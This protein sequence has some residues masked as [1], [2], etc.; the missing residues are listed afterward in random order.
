MAHRLAVVFFTIISQLYRMIPNPQVVVNGNPPTYV[1]QE[2][3]YAK[4]IPTLVVPTGKPGTKSY[5]DALDELFHR[6]HNM[7]VV[8][9]RDRGSRLA[10][11]FAQNS[12][13]NYDIALRGKLLE[14]DHNDVLSPRGQRGLGKLQD[15]SFFSTN[16]SVLSGILA[17]SPLKFSVDILNPEISEEA[18]DR[19][20]EAGAEGFL[21][22]AA[23]KVSQQVG[24]DVGPSVTDPS[25]YVAPTAEGVMAPLSEKEEDASTL[26][27]M[28]TSLTHETR[29]E[30]RLSQCFDDQ[31]IVNAEMMD[32]YIENTKVKVKRLTG[33]QVAWLGRDDIETA[34]DAGGWGIF[35]MIPATECVVA[36]GGYMEDIGGVEGFSKWVEAGRKKNPVGMGNYNQGV[37]TYS[38]SYY[39]GGD[40]PS[41]LESKVYVKLVRFMKFGLTLDG[42]ELS[43][44]QV[45]AFRARR[46][47]GAERVLYTTLTDE[48]AEMQKSQ[49][50]AIH[51]L[52]ITEVWESVM[53]GGEHLMYRRKCQCQVRRM[54]ERASARFP[55]VAVFNEG[56]SLVTK[57]IPLHELHTN[58]MTKVRSQVAM[59]GMKS[60]VVDRSELGD[61]QTVD[62]LLIEAGEL[63]LIVMN[64]QRKSGQPT[65]E[66]YRHLTT[67]DLGLN[68]D[69]VKLLNLAAAL[70]EMYDN[71]CGVT[72]A[73]KGQFANREALGQ[74]QMAKLQGTLI[75]QRHFSS[76]S[77]FTRMVIEN[78]ADMGKYLWAG[79]GRKRILLGE[80]GV[81]TLMLRESLSRWDYGIYLSDSMKA[82]KD[83][84]FL[85]GVAQNG[86]SSGQTNIKDILEMYYTDNPYKMLGIFRDGL[87]AYERLEA[88]QMQARTEAQ[89]TMADAASK[90]ATSTVD[91]ANI[92]GQWKM[93]IEKLRQEFDMKT[94]E[95]A[96]E[97]EGNTVDVNHQQQIKRDLMQSA[98]QQQ[99]AQQNDYAA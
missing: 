79:Q 10:G 40:V 61:D 57:G 71:I 18:L 5:E 46:F 67:V 28:L 6:I 22:A 77:E 98:T 59:S 60:L 1:S 78:V 87:S 7:M 93:E 15:F 12:L 29:L 43:D 25:I 72:P 9:W 85:L 42:V 16:L 37:S 30:R 56:S 27:D 74:T 69:I 81:K 49:G 75:S 24:I 44:E 48:E 47:D 65:K 70:R 84:E 4:G 23:E 64:G 14:E 34:E 88:Q 92:T 31:G 99:L 39:H 3:N 95:D 38:V 54:G 35:N 58:I 36:Y 94:R 45:K 63:G 80:Q 91:A 17:E 8:R 96:Q 66:S 53:L 50:R 11:P 51:T 73:M 13:R 26:F 55:L 33:D 41:L 89:Q 97:F 20:A 90:K 52:P 83:R 82:T 76:H 32:I 19:V 86:M 68:D 21:R 62:S 2:G